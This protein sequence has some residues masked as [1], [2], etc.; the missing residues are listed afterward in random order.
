[1]VVHSLHPG[2]LAQVSIFRKMASAIDLKAQDSNPRQLKKKICWL[3]LAGGYLNYVFSKSH[4]QTL[5]NSGI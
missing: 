3:D 4:D 5:P 2:P 1:M